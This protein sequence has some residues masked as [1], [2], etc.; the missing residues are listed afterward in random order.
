[1]IQYGMNDNDRHEM[2]VERAWAIHRRES[3]RVGQG[4]VYRSGE[5]GEAKD[6]VVEALKILESHD[7]GFA[8][9]YGRKREV[10]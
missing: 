8:K 7:E 9:Y 5:H 4:L 1:M 3:R 2:T 6:D 10:K